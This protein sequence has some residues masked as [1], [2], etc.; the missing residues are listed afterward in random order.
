MR[1]MQKI[2]KLS[3]ILYMYRALLASTSVHCFGGNFRPVTNASVGIDQ[4][5]SRQ[6]DWFNSQTFSRS[7]KSIYSLLCPDNLSN[8]CQG[9][10]WLLRAIQDGGLA[11]NLNLHC[12]AD[13]ISDSLLNFC[14]FAQLLK[15]EVSVLTERC[16]S[17]GEHHSWNL[18]MYALNIDS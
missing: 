3:N 13:M 9:L 11:V 1:N 5:I 17:V 6:F 7:S 14:A 18:R 4:P 12:D 15:S 8:E 10:L 2:G 16:P